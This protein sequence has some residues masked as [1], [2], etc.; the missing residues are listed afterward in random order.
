ML[1][2]L[3]L[4]LAA[5]L[6]LGVDPPDDPD[7]TDPP[8]NPDDPDPLDLGE[9]DPDPP[10]GDADPDDPDTIREQLKAERTARETAE[11]NAREA[12]ERATA[13]EAR[14]RESRAPPSQEQQLFEHEETRLRDPALTAQ[15]KWQIE[16]NRVLRSNQREARQALAE[17]RE[18]A[19]KSDYDRYAASNPALAKRYTDRVEKKLVEIRAT[20]GN[21]PRKVLLKMLIGEDIV[22]GKV[23][24]TKRTTDGGT[25]QQPRTVDR[26]KPRTGRSDV[27]GR[28]AST[29]QEKRRARLENQII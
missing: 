17:S 24:S 8:D 22:D 10:G 7:N 2:R 3:Y 23:K 28:G 11:R 18:I 25:T 14:S 20:G 15:E 19:D 26:G 29:E 12:S 21:I 5:F 16:S 1:I 9:D 6:T 13:A 27:R 4:L